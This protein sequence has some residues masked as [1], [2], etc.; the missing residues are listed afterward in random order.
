MTGVS[1]HQVV[2]LG[3]PLCRLVNAH[4]EAGFDEVLF[5]ADDSSPEQ[6][7]DLNGLVSKRAW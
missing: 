3:E 7:H 2:A 5:G 4:E 1:P 6:V